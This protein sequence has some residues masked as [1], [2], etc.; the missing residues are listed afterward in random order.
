MRP[1]I[2]AYFRSVAEQYQ[3]VDRV[4][5]HSIVEK[6]EWDEQD[7]TWVVTILDTKTKSR[8]VRRAK[9]LV[10]AVGALSVPKECNVPGKDDFKGRMFHSAK[11]DWSF[12][13]KGK[14]VVVL[15]RLSILKG[16]STQN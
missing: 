10:S 1:E 3:V 16:V 6:A 12:D 9:V 2:Q 11:W 4:R 13:W 8:Q 14:D 7:K 5:F 15:G